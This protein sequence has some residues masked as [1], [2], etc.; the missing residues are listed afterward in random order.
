MQDDDLPYFTFMNV[1]NEKKKIL[2]NWLE[3]KNELKPTLGPSLNDYINSITIDNSYGAFQ[4]V[5]SDR[6]KLFAEV[7][8][9]IDRLLVEI[10]KRFKPSEA[11]ERFLVLFEPG[12]L[13]K[14]IGEVA[15]SNYGRKEL[16][17]LRNKYQTLKGFDKDKSMV[18]WEKLK[19]SLSEFA[20]N[21]QNKM[22]RRTF[23]KDFIFWKEATDDCFHE[24][25]RNI[26]ILLSIYLISPL[27]SAV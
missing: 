25:Y 20:Q 8:L 16:D 18:E 11:Q 10:D 26:L 21:N 12:C 7:F 5:P 22:S 24:R 19:I 17:F 27:N 13:V 6:S 2:R 15:K 4:I 23:W 3:Q 1:L 14:N 9:H